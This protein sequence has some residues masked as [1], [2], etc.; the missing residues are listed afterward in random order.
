MS[1]LA[2]LAGARN[3]RGRAV[4]RSAGRAA[5]LLRVRP[6]LSRCRRAPIGVCKVRF[7]DGGTL[8]VPWGYVG[9]VQCDPIEKKPF[10]HAYPGALAYS[11][12]MLGC[13]LH[14]GY[15]QNWV[16]S[17]ALRD[18]AAVAPPHPGR[19]PEDLVRDAVRQ[20]RAVHGQH[21]QRAADHQRMGGRGLQGSEG[22][23]P[24]HRRSCRTATARRRCSN[25]SGRGSISTRSISRA[26]TTGT[27]A[28]LAGG[29]APIL[30]TIRRLHAMGFWL[31]IVTL[32]I[33]GFNDSRDEIERLTSFIAGVSPRHPVARH[34]VSRRLQDDRPGEHDRRDAARR[35]RRSAA[36][37]ACATSTPAICRARSATSKT[38]LRVVRRAPHPPPRLPHPRLPHHAGRTAARRAPRAVPGR[39]SARFDGQIASRPFRPNSQ[40]RLLNPDERPPRPAAAQP[41]ALGH[42][43]LQPALRI[44]HAG[45]RLRRGC[46]ART[47]CTSRRSAR[48]STCSSSLGV[49]K[50]RLTGGEPLLRRDIAVARRACSPPSRGSPIWR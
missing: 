49:D 43:P 17:Q 3:A 25:T 38:P 5:A 14:C 16:T 23:G 35:P 1:S 34:R 33:P 12:G 21:L 11:F 40:F 9:G 31:E 19:R 6:L 22:G 26:S 7:N 45:G 30:D 50:V 4:R 8:R 20:R 27:T 41:A 36:P 29:S 39:W 10:F 48:W 47:C 32:L 37:T 42:R 28:S 13:D 18:P 2:E 44:L 15:C 24:G 46:R